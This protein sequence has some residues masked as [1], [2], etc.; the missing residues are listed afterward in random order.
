MSKIEEVINYIRV[1]TNIPNYGVFIITGL[2]LDNK[3]YE[4]I[5]DIYDFL[6]QNLKYYQNMDLIQFDKFLVENNMYA[7]TYYTNNENNNEEN[8]KN[9]NENNNKNNNENNCNLNIGKIYASDD[10]LKIKY[11]VTNINNFTEKDRIG[12][13]GVNS[14]VSY[15]ENCKE[16]TY[17][18]YLRNTNGDLEKAIVFAY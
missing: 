15:Y 3:K 17:Y 10:E 11:S 18:F 7:N 13:S 12:W 8:K 2:L 14:N 5:N 6:M 16:N 9:N 4:Q 1:N